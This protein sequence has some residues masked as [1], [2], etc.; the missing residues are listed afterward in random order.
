MTGHLHRGSLLPPSLTCPAAPG[1]PLRGAQA[2]ELFSRAVL[3]APT[4]SC[5]SQELMI[6]HDI[7][8]EINAPAVLSSCFT[9]AAHATA[10]G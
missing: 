1:P 3:Q 2:T 9:A 8:Q 7:A 4:Q 10:G 5:S 6:C